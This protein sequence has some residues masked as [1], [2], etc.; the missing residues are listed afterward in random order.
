MACCLRPALAVL[1]ARFG[2]VSET[3]KLA[4]QENSTVIRISSHLAPSVLQASFLTQLDR[5]SA[6]RA[7][8]GKLLPS[9][10]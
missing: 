6:M 4:P 7:R 8:K 9:Q 5:S 2:P 3:A 1:L 10:E